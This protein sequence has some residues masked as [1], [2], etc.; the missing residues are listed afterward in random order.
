LGKYSLAEDQSSVPIHPW[1][2]HA[3]CRASNIGNWSLKTPELMCINPHINI[4]TSL[5]IIKID[6]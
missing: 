5:K 2:N 1:N 3:N 6:L 4:Y